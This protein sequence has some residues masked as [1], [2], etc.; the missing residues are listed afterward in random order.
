MT[1]YRVV[2]ET[3]GIGKVGWSGSTEVYLYATGVTTTTTTVAYGC[4]LPTYT[5][6]Y[7]YN[8]SC[9]SITISNEVDAQNACDDYNN[10]SCTETT[11]SS[12]DFNVANQTVGTQLYS[13]IT[14]LTIGVGSS[15]RMVLDGSNNTY[16]AYINAGTIGTFY[17]R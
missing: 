9:R 13:P 15:W 6:Y 11:S 2:Y 17:A 1:I 5:W 4:T 3:G 7:E 10:I 8:T 16:V 14:C 12:T